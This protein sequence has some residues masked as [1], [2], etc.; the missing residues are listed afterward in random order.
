MIKIDRENGC[1]VQYSESPLKLPNGEIVLF[2]I[3]GICQPEGVNDD[4][5]KVFLK[6]VET[7]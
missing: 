1:A 2:K 5:M 7:I 3:E 6:H 4:D